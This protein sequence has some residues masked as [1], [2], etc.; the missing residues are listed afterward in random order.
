M[1]IDE[2][3]TLGTAAA[4]S[5]VSVWASVPD[6]VDAVVAARPYGSTAALRAHA[7]RTAARWSRAELDAALADH[8]RIGAK[9]SGDGAQ[10][11]ASRREQASMADAD[12][13]VSARIAAQNRAYE[14]R[15][16][17]VFLVRAAGR[18]P[19]EM[20]TE[21][22]R[23]LGHDE[24]TEVAEACGQLAEIALLR[25]RESITDDLTADP[26]GTAS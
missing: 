10:A 21:L 3:D 6:W 5:V 11:Q 14:Q 26:G 16:G 19:E 15:F 12:A 9:P 20:L 4:R 23:R 17:R 18:S 8:P 2:F 13:D 25:L 1:H 22:D 24:P 7:E